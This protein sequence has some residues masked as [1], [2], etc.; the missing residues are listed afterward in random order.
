MAKQYYARLWVDKFKE[1]KLMDNNHRLCK[2]NYPVQVK[3][4]NEECEAELLQSI[5]S[6]PGSCSQRIVELNQTLWTQLNNNELLYVAPQVDTLTVLCSGQE[7][8]DVQIR[9]TGK[10][11]L[12]SMCKGYGSKVLIQAQVTITSNNTSKDIILPLSLDYD[13]CL[14]EERNIK[15]NSIHLDLPMKS[16][17]NHLDDLKLASYRAEEIETHNR[18][19]VKTETLQYRLSSL[20]SVICRNDD[21]MYNFGHFLLRLLLQMFP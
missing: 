20:F 17:V 21:Y 7:P 13:C 3:H 8:T 5:R 6:I 16:V 18:G 19:R 15:L 1:C 10:L 4:E 9:G 11:K 12:L 2:Q 14:P